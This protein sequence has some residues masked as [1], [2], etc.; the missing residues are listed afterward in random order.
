MVQNL[1]MKVCTGALSLELYVSCH[2]HESAI[3]IDIYQHMVLRQVSIDTHT[4]TRLT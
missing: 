2:Q 3:V 4:P 1:F